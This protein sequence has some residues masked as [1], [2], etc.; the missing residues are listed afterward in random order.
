ME[1]TNTNK[2]V[3]VINSKGQEKLTAKA[4]TKK[5]DANKSK[6]I[7]GVIIGGV[8]AFLAFVIGVVSII[9]IVISVTRVTL[10]DYMQAEP[11]Y[12]GVN[13]Y[14]SVD[15]S[16]L[17]DY[18][19][20]D[21][22]IRNKNE[23]NNEYYWFYGDFATVRDYISIEYPENNGR[24]SNGDEIEITVYIDKEGIKNN[25]H[26]KKSISGSDTQTF[27]Y[28][29]SGLSEP[30]V[31]DAFDAVEKV[32]YDTVSDSKTIYAKNEYVRNYENGVS[33]SYEYGQLRI[34]VNDNWAYTVC[35]EMN[36]DELLPESQKVTLY[37][38][39]AQDEY[40]A[41]GIIFESA[42]KEFDV[43]VIS[44]LKTLNIKDSEVKTLKNLAD[45]Y[46]NDN[47]GAGKHTFLKAVGYFKTQGEGMY[48]DLLI[49]YY[50]VDNKTYSAVFTEL[51]QDQNANIYKLDETEV[52]TFRNWIF[53][54]MVSHDTA[55]E[56]EDQNIDFD[57][58]AEL[59]IPN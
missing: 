47:F 43:T 17:I 35:I 28:T 54:E 53:N 46:M 52:K 42:E 59:T 40:A 20:L 7:K 44:R 34:S 27:K 48:V 9:A 16:E 26:F 50:T 58:K 14:G 6:I 21:E 36:K 13:G 38:D 51:K 24:L 4:A 31:I 30:V 8:S 22:K 32:V 10:D 33:V 56:F 12:I 55:E 1:T 15:A 57:G 3:E 5:S 2:K 23:E 18:D 29:V 37:I 41:D 39:R 45:N 25:S 19:A 11:Q 49:F